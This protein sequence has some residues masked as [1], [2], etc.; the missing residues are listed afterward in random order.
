MKYSRL[1]I[2]A[3]MAALFTVAV[4]AAPP[5]AAAD[6]AEEARAFVESMADQAI[7]ALTP[8]GISRGER[9]RRF[10]VLFNEDFAVHAIGVWVLGRY[11][12]RATPEEQ[13]TYMGL[14]EDYIVASYVDSFSTYAGE[15]LKIVKTIPDDASSA[16][17]YSEIVLPDTGKTPVRVNWRIDGLNS[18]PKVVDVVVEGVSMS[19]TLRSE[20]G[21]I[22]RREGGHLAGLLKV[23]RDKA[24]MLRADN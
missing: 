6:P 2:A 3:A 7:Q 12:N 15:K 1:P 5:A 10:R 18:T 4:A 20:F 23:L 19:T 21:S 17:V 9:I 22:I 13:K 16:T 11:W 8:T 24:Q 14:F